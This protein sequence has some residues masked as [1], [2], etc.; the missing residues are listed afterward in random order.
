MHSSIIGRIIDAR[1]KSG[2]N[3]AAIFVLFAIFFY[4]IPLSNE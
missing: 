4:S 1:T 3:V 2:N